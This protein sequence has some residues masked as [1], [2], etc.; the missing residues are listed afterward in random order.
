VNG[1]SGQGEFEVFWV[2]ETLIII[3]KGLGGIRAG[4]VAI[5]Q[6]KERDRTEEGG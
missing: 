3:M 6:E 2:E 1:F 5:C 4:K